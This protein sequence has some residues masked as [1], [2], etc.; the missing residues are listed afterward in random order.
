MRTRKT[1]LPNSSPESDI[2]R[3]FMISLAFGIVPGQE[4][5]MMMMRRMTRRREEEESW[6][7]RRE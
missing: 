4:E 5:R 6:R 2:F 7:R 3:R 1:S